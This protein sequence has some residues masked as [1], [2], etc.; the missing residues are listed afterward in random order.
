MKKKDS[1]DINIDKYVNGIKNLKIDLYICGQL[2]F[3]IGAKR[4]VEEAQSSEIMVMEQFNIHIY[5]KNEL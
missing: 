5:Q 1:T 3:D 2:N 4:S